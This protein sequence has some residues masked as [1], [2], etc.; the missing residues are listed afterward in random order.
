MIAG[1]DSIAGE[2]Q[3]DEAASAVAAPV[4][5]RR[6]PRCE[7]CGGRTLQENDQGDFT[8][9]TCGNVI[10]AVKPL[11][12]PDTGRRERRPSHGGKYL[13]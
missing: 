4:I 11:L 3:Q 2:L 9:F 6:F 13:S 10:Y 12:I 7:R 8:C 1:G 5:P